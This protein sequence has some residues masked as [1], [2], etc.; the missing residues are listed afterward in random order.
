[1]RSV[2][3]LRFHNY[4][5]GSVRCVL[6]GTRPERFLNRCAAAGIPFWDMGYETPNRLTLFLSAR[7]F[8]RI[9]PVARAAGCTLRLTERHGALYTARRLRRRAV[10]LAGAALLTALFWVLNTR[11]LSME[12]TGYERVPPAVI[13]AAMREEGVGIWT[14]TREVDASLLRNHILLRVPEL[15]WF[16]VVI[17]GSHAVVDVRERRPAPQV[18]DGHDPADIL[19]DRDGVITQLRLFRGEA[20]AQEGQLVHRG[21]LL[22]SGLVHL[23]LEE[24]TL[25][26]H[27]LADIYA[28]VW[29]Q[30][31]AAMPLDGRI[32][33]QTGRKSVRFALCVGNRRINFYKDGGNLFDRYDKISNRYR[34]CL[35]DGSILPVSLVR[36]TYYEYETYAAALDQEDAVRRLSL[37]VQDRTAEQGQGSRVTGLD[38]R[39]WVRDRVLYVRAT[40]ESVQ[41]IGVTVL[42]E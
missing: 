19:A 31:T 34:I 30:S 4:M 40:G 14:P 2:E 5:R 27:A 21:D 37:V 35:T 16:T 23:R 8:R 42:R 17:R 15:S 28:R 32:K 41:K 39:A 7:D 9:R 33:V 26:T 3:L 6:Q 29:H 18:L 38:L 24:K 22:V 25:L 11:I 10:L 13:L 36:E 12:V 1:M 20:R